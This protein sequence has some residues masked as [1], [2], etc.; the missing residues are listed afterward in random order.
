MDQRALVERAGGG[1]HDAFAL[2]V[3]GIIARPVG[4]FAVHSDGTGLRPLT[5]VDGYPDYSYQQPL[6]SPD[7]RLLTF[8]SWV[9][10]PGQMRIHIVD[11]ETGEDQVVTHP[12]DPSEGYATFSPD[13]SRIVFVRY[14]GSSDQIWVRPVAA[15][16]KPV[17][18]GPAYPQVDGQYIGS[19]FSPDGK[20]VIVNDPASKETRLVDA[21]TGGDGEV[22]PWSTGGFS[23]QR[24]AP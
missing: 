20:S 16:S 18:A 7:G 12:L 4:V 11:L 14:S 21:V 9:P 19:S 10:N 17:A 23:W 15:G 24:V 13:G 1:D 6:L 3:R 2:L 8:T 5:P 22:V